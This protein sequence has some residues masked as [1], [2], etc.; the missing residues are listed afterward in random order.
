MTCR[1]GP[2]R[3]LAAGKL[4]LSCSANRDLHI[5]F[6]NVIFTGD[7]NSLAL[8][9]DQRDVDRWFNMTPGSTAIRHSNWP[10]TCAP[11]RCGS[12]ACAAMIS[13]AGTFR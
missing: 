12:V 4:R 7:I 1:A 9:G 3:L 2:I 13:N 6:G 11:S 8:D 10:V 5:G